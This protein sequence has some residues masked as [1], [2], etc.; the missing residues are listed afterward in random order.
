MSM[1]RAGRG[2][3]G[4]FREPYGGRRER[5]RSPS[6]DPSENTEASASESS[7]KLLA[8]SQRTLQ[9]L[10]GIV[11]SLFLGCIL[12]SDGSDEPSGLDFRLHPLARSVRSG[13]DWMR[14]GTYTPF[15]WGVSFLKGV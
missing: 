5:G 8:R 14:G 2:R 10:C 11:P 1:E 3:T 9:Q 15:E 7:A 4:R 12:E 13:R 6:G